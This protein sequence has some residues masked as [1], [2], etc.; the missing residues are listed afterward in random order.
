[1]QHQVFDVAAHLGHYRF[2]ALDAIGDAVGEVQ[3][4]VVA[5]LGAVEVVDLD[6]DLG[7]ALLLGVVGLARADIVD[8]GKAVVL[9]RHFQEQAFLLT[10]DE[11]I[12]GE[13]QPADVLSAAGRHG[14][15][16]VP[17][18]LSFPAVRHV[19]PAR[20][21]IMR[22]SLAFKGYKEKST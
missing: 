19:N 6:D 5:D 9:P 18:G 22:K 13:F 1:M 10:L 11:A 17:L 7:Q 16:D 2:I 3:L 12:V 4:V 8:R 21:V 20:S 14:L 15:D